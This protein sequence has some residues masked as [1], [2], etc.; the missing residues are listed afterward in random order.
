[1]ILYLEIELL[2]PF[3][4]AGDNIQSPTDYSQASCNVLQ[5]YFY[6]LVLSRNLNFD[7]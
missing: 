6:V 4:F 1:M 3:D 7:L 2:L 5:G